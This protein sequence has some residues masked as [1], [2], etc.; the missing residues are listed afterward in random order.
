MQY[1]LQTEGLTKKYGNKV[2]VNNVSI[3]IA[4]GDIYGFIGNNGAGKTSFMKMVL[5]LTFPT[6]GS[7]K[8]FDGADIQES[9]RKIGSLV[10]TPSLYGSITARENLKTYCVE[11]GFDDSCIDELLKLVSLDNVEKLPVRKFSL[12][13]KQRL[14]IAIAMLNEPEFMILDEPVN[15]L[16]PKGIKEIRE[17]VLKLNQEKGVT[18]LISSHLLDELGKIATRYGIISGG[19]LKEELT[20]QTLADHCYD[21]YSIKTTDNEKALESLHNAYPEVEIE[22]KD[23]TIIFKSIEFGAA[24][25]SKVISDNG[26]YIIEIRE[27]GIKPEDYFIERM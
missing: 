22:I 20:A 27:S 23:D 3:N 7:I 10:E 1:I 6:S 9:R 15:G 24:D 14:G 13:M 16:D 17:L 12:G 21:S 11:F 2:V 19:Y 18:F 4:K 5:G 25:L 8:L 26:A